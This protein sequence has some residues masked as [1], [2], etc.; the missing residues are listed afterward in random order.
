M[1]WSTMTTTPGGTVSA[2]DGMA[3]VRA[4]LH[5]FLARRVES[6]EVADDLTQE[7]LLRLLQA[8]TH[9]QGQLTDPM[10]WLYRVA[11]NVLIDHYRTRASHTQLDPDPTIAGLAE[12]PF[13]D[14]PHAAHRELAGCL[15][16][17][18]GQ[19]PEPY[20]TA[21]VGVDLDGQTQT[22]LA[23]TLGLSV[24]GMKSRVQRGRQQLGQLLTRCCQ[25]N[26]SPTGGIT[27]YEPTGCRSDPAAGT[28]ARCNSPC[29]TL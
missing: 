12:D 4:R 26:T 18:V 1:A 17:L 19:L 14:D 3:A 13:A 2:R 25:V 10:A 29:T 21:V 28:G 27:G 20:R 6:P 11:R 7:V 24:S 23:R 8:T 15:R 5:A 22:D 16:Q 9:G